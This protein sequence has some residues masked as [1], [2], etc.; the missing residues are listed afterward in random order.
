MKSPLLALPIFLIAC[1]AAFA[2]FGQPAPGNRM[3]GTRVM[4]GTSSAASNA[5]E[6]SEDIVAA[7]VESGTTNAAPRRKF[8]GVPLPKLS[9][10]ALPFL[11]KKEAAQPTVRW[12]DGVK[13]AKKD[14]VYGITTGSPTKFYPAVSGQTSR[15]AEA[16][17]P[18]TMVVYQ[19]TSKRWAWINLK[20]RKGYVSLSDLRPA[21]VEEAPKPP[22]PKPKPKPK[23]APKKAKP[24][25]PLSDPELNEEPPLPDVDPLAEP[26]S[27][28]IEDPSLSDPPVETET[29]P[30]PEPSLPDLS[31]IESVPTKPSESLKLEGEDGLDLR[32]PTKP[33]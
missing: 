17:A 12:E 13:T 8:L 33:E 18:G 2:Q 25:S 26:K 10:P 3:W 31:P 24:R 27:K 22:K 28:P 9:K 21:T 32:D 5:R 16:I 23:A 19:S 1:T 29:K 7:P 30:D 14:G 11:K 15:A 4:P 6:R 20:G